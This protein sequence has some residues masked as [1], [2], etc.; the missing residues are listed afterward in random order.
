MEGK[1]QPENVIVLE[2][3]RKSRGILWKNEKITTENC[4][5]LGEWWLDSS[6][7]TVSCKICGKWLNPFWCMETLARQDVRLV[8]KFKDAKKA[9][10][11]LLDRLAK[12]AKEMRFQATPHRIIRLEKLLDKIEPKLP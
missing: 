1:R 8:R 10:E 6:D 3:V 2:E 12:L 11:P 4:G 9:L 7:Q 5:H